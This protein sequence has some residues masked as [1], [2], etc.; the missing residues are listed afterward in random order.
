MKVTQTEIQKYLAQLEQ[1]PHLIQAAAE[2]VDPAHL[3]AKIGKDWSANDVLAHLRACAD[4]WGASIESML[5][6]DEPTLPYLHPNQWLKQTDY[7]QLEFGKSLKAYTRQR[8][9]LLKILTKVPL[10]DWARGAII[11]GRKHTVF[12]QARRM[13]L[14]EIEHCGQIGSLLHSH[15]TLSPAK[16]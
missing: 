15:E 12:S 13:A 6:E 3:H 9:K 10:V 2:G 5:A 11:G 1:T 8:Q 14:H 7:R 4:V 16:S